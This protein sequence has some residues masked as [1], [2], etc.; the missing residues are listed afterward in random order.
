M[1]V[2]KNFDFETGVPGV[3]FFGLLA[4]MKSCDL[5]APEVLEMLW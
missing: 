3:A 1:L 4:S 5:S 2:A